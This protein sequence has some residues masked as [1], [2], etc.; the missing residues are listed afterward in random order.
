MRYFV[1]YVMKF[2]TTV[3]VNAADKEDAAT[4]ARLRA[5][6]RV[7][8]GGDLFPDSVDIIEVKEVPEGRAA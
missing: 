7:G 5:Q 8:D 2:E 6:L 4:K 3:I 1:T